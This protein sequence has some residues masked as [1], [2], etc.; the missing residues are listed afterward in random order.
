MVGNLVRIR[1]MVFILLVVF[2]SK[3]VWAAADTYPMNSLRVIVPTQAG[4]SVDLVGRLL[5]SELTKRLGKTFVVDDRGGAGGIIGV[6]LAAKSIAD[7]YTLLVGHQ[8]ARVERPV[9]R[10]LPPAHQQARPLAAAAIRTLPIPRLR[11]AHRPPS[12]PRK[13]R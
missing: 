5:A 8:F 12:G 1:K 2:L 13:N 4:G 11:S 9:Y 7:G 6:D 3:D 10:R